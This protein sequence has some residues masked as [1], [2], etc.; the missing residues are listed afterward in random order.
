VDVTG[1]YRHWFEIGCSLANE[2]RE[3]GREHFH[4]VSQFYAQYQVAETDKQYDACLKYRY[5]YT[6]AT[7]YKFCQDHGICLYPQKVKT[8]SIPERT[9]PQNPVPVTPAALSATGK[10][11]YLSDKHPALRQLVTALDLEAI[12]SG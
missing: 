1:G 12:E 10:L 7:F 4:A 5:R 3:A 9:L 11:Q 6:I 2:L 8:F